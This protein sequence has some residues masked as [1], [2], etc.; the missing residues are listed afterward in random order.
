[1]IYWTHY[2]QSFVWGND[3]EIGWIDSHIHLMD[4]DLLLQIDDV[5]LRAQENDVVRIMLIALS[6]AEFELGLRLLDKYP[7]LDLAVGF[8][9]SDIQNVTEKNYQK[10]EDTLKSGKISAIG[11]IGLDYYWDKTHIDAQRLHFRRQIELSIKYELPIIIHMREATQEVYDILSEYKGKI[12]GV[13][14]CYSGSVEMAERFIGIGFLISFGGPLT[15]KNANLNLQVAQEIP[16]D[17]ILIETDGPYLTPHPFRGK[18]NES[19]YVK[20]VG[21]KLA[22]L[23]NS[24]NFTVQS[25]IC[26][27]YQ[28]LFK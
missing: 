28:R 10:L 13:M 27:N 12:K 4:E 5:I 11:E 16:L 26:E 1:M 18:I 23:R 7:M 19:M 15:F 20:Y 24:D 6:E 8:H 14:H 17:K 22:E 9:P 2:F 25:Q 21:E 3:M